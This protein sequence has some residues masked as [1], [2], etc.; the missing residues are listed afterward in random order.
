MKTLE[1]MTS[2]RTVRSAIQYWWGFL[3]VGI[4]MVLMGLWL[5]VTPLESYLALAFAFSLLTLTSGIVEILFAISNRKEY[6]GWGWYLCGGILDLI[7]GFILVKNPDI[8]I[9][10]LPYIIAFWLMFRG[11]M[12]IGSSLELRSYHTTGW[13]F[14]LLS[15]ILTILF[16]LLMIKNPLTGEF[17]IVWMASMAFISG[18]IFRIYISF[19]LKRLHHI[20]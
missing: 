1:N 20:E 2:F 15:G 7:L 10:V 17:V 6:E 5:F 3:L 14:L 4:L 12:A 19:K 8:S 18:G 13:G 16:S 11:A 9:E